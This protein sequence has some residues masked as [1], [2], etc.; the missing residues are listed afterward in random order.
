MAVVQVEVPE[1]LLF[2]LLH[3]LVHLLSGNPLQADLMG[4]FRLLPVFV[5]QLADIF[6]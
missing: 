4:A 5:H 6:V 2:H 1:E 3:V